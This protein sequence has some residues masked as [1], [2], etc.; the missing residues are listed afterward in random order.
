MVQH[1][2]SLFQI[3][4]NLMLRQFHSKYKH[5][6]EFFFT[7][8]VAVTNTKNCE[9]QHETKEEFKSKSL[10]C[11]HFI[12][13]CGMTETT[14]ISF[15]QQCFHWS[16]TS[17]GTNALNHDIKQSTYKTH[18]SCYQLFTNDGQRVIFIATIEKLGKN[19]ADSSETYHGNSYCWIYMSTAHMSNSLNEIEDSC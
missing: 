10:Q 16:S 15:R 11:C 17:Y 6:S 18:F 8:L 9:D 7:W 14:M 19:L 1:I 2:S 13:Q 4:L 5:S 12:G 3:K